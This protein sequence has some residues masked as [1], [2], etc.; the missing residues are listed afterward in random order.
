MKIKLFGSAIGVCLAVSTGVRTQTPAT[1]PVG[2]RSQDIGAVGQV[3]SATES[4]GIFTVSAAGAD[5]WSTADAFHFAYRPLTGDGTIVAEVTSLLGAEAWTKMGVMIRASI[6][7]GSTHAF[8]MVSVAKGLAFQRRTVAGGVSTHTSGGAGAAPRWVK[9]SRAGSTIT[10]SASS[11]GRTWTVVGRD[12]ITMP[13]TV[14]VGLAA[15]SHDVTRLA[16]GTFANVAIR[17]DTGWRSRDIGVVGQPGSATESGGVFTVRGAGADIWGTADAFH[18]V[19]R[20]LTGD[21]TIVARVTSVVGAQA[22]TKM[23]VMIRASTAPGSAHAFM[24]VS[25]A[26]GLAFQRRTVAGGVSTHTSGGAGAAPRWVKLTRAGPTITASASLDGRTWTVVGSDTFSMPATV[27][28]GLAATSHDA[29][30]LATGTFASVVMSTA[31]AVSLDPPITVDGIGFGQGVEVRDGKVYL[32]GDAATGVIREYDVNESRALRYTGRQVRLVASGRDVISHPTG[33][34]TQRGLGTLIGDTVTQRGTLYFIDWAR[35]LATGTLE[36]AI[37]ATIADDLAV[38]GT[39]PEFVRLGD[40]W[41]VATADYGNEGN[42][43]RLYD[44]AR[45]RTAA[46]TSEPGVLVAR[47]RSSTLVQTLHWLDDPGLLVLVQNQRWAAGWRLTAIDLARSVQA[48]QQVVTLRV[49]LLPADE[50]EGFHM[51]APG[52]GLF[53]TSSAVSNAYFAN[54]RLH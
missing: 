36:G 9:L 12:T 11:D 26:K 37:L 54:V 48:G 53:L 25:A 19:Y 33:L 39:R 17:P 38:N 22:W 45:L 6:Q 21:G 49:D 30:R 15:T 44:P 2:W 42:E 28:V 8:M 32:Y 29:T 18:F 34:T 23:G 31:P 10:A 14:L 27:L 43:V 5:I 51:V 13:A 16:T 46:R 50:L 3:G 4:G 1:L 41:L 47:F 40:R 35:A 24:L 20:P 7:P 52:R